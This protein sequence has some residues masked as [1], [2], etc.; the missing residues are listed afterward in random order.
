MQSSREKRLAD[1]RR[2]LE[3]QLRGWTEPEMKAAKVS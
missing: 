2:L 1:V 3:A